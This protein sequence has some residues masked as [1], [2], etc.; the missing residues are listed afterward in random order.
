MVRRLGCSRQLLVKSYQNPEARH[1]DEE[2]FGDLK[3]RANKILKH[4]VK[5]HANQSILLVSHATTIKSIVFEAIFGENLTPKLFWNIRRHIITKNTGV[6]I[7]EYSKKRGW[8]LVTWG[9]VSHL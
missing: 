3:I 2:S 6:T 4:L 5:N 9:D 7:I 1:S 8:A